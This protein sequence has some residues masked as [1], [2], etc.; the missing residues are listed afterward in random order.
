[1]TPRI[2]PGF[3]L[4]VDGGNSKTAV[5]VADLEGQIVG[6]AEGAPS[7]IYVARAPETALD[8]L[9]AG[10]RE[11]LSDAG[12]GVPDL[13]MSAFSLA[14][15][16]WPEDFAFLR[17]EITSRLKLDHRPVVVNDAIGGLRSGTD[18]G[19][20][21]AVVCGTFNAVGARHRD[22][23]VFHLGFWPDRTGGVDL[24][25]EALRAVYREAL[26]LGP[27]TG[28][29]PRALAVFGATDGLAL[30]HAFTRRENRLPGW[31]VQR[32]APV[33]LDCA[34]AGDAV[35][36]AIVRQAGGWLGDEARMSARRVGVDRPGCPVVLT[37]GVFR[38]PTT[39]LAD[40]V[41]ERLPDAV[42]V[43]ATVPPLVGPLLLALDELGLP[44]DRA[45]LAD[46]LSVAA[47]VRC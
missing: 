42:A 24:G 43:R 26:D 47:D 31:D 2:L 33:L 20:G 34:D 18:D 38:H 28:L 8:A 37:G 27:P 30:L 10:V 40:A 11:A 32:M 35:S 23:R 19:E 9:V 15:C 36:V 16:D 5:A 29:T 1:M 22:G 17:C 14:G 4:G 39:V 21:V 46:C 3:V 45:K 13:A 6:R 41:M 25:T 12:V 44:A 7:D